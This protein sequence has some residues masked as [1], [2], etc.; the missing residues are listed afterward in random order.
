MPPLFAGVELKKKKYA[1]DDGRTIVNMN[2][3][4]MPWY[5]PTVS[6]KKKRNK[7]DEPTKKEFFAMVKAA[8]VAYFPAFCCMLAGLTMAF[9]FLYLWFNGWKV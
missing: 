6:G 3:E 7:D 1:D 2:V 8:F 4:G 9:F 5:N